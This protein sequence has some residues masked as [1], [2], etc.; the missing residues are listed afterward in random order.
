MSYSVRDTRFLGLLFLT[1]LGAMAFGAVGAQAS[2]YLIE[3]GGVKK[4]FVEH[5][6]ESETFSGSFGEGEILNTANVKVNCG[7]A[8]PSGTFLAGGVV[9]F[10][11]LYSGC[12][13]LGN[14]N[15]VIYET[16]KDHEKKQFP[17]YWQLSG[18]GEEIL[19]GGAHYLKIEGAAL[20]TIWFGDV[21]FPES[22]ALALSLVVAGSLAFKLPNVLTPALSQTF[23][24]ITAAEATSLR[25]LFPAF[26][27]TLGGKTADLKEGS[28]GLLFLSGGLKDKK[29]GAH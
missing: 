26:G 10:T 12:E 14:K 15:C 8:S 6:I 16:Q 24:T 13:V 2:E 23:Q 22:C 19:H 21:L 25:N 4:T 20:G 27:L 18:L 1:V 17:G 29:W 28:S 3:E 9:H 11:I 7:S 5:G